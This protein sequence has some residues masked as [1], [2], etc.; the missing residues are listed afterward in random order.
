MS[1]RAF[2]NSFF[3]VI[4]LQ[5]QTEQTNPAIRQERIASFGFR[6]AG[7]AQICRKGFFPATGAAKGTV[8]AIIPQTFSYC[9]K[10]RR[11]YAVFYQ[12]FDFSIIYV[13]KIGKFTDQSEI[14]FKIIQP[15]RGAETFF[16][17]GLCHMLRMTHRIP[18]FF[19]VIL[20]L[21]EI[22]F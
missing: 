11:L 21:F 13:G 16:K 2:F 18:L 12:Q 7:A 8:E 4:Y 9:L 19:A 3:T 20:G 1:F 14:T 22:F 10:N 5:P 15:D 17:K 6:A